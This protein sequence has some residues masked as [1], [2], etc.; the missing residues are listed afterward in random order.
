MINDR[1]RAIAS[2]RWLLPLF[3]LGMGGVVLLAGWLGGQLAA[4]VYGLVVLA[5]F[6]LAALLLGGPQRDHPRPDDR[7]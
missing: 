5:V 4:G 7:P 6:G 1:C 3:S 2:S